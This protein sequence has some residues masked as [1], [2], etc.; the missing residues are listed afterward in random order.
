[1]T[2]VSWRPFPSATIG[3]L[4]FK[5]VGVHPFTEALPQELALVEAGFTVQAAGGLRPIKKAN[6][7][8]T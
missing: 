7:E 5:M 6:G 2:C 1:M 3:Q 4:V 8:W